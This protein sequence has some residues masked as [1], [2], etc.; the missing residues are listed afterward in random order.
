M[1]EEQRLGEQL[2]A[3]RKARRVTGAELAEAIGVTQ[4][5]VSKMETGRLSPDID[6]LS[7]FA[8]I[9]RLEPT[10]AAELMRLA[11]VVP[12]R[13]HAGELSSFCAL[14]FPDAELGRATPGSGPRGRAPKLAH[15][16]LPAPP[17]SRT[18][19]NRGLRTA[20][21]HPGRSER[22]AHGGAR[23]AFPGFAGKCCWPTGTRRSRS[24][25]PKPPCDVAWRPR[26]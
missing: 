17:G 4:G 22:P 25:S 14:R 12:R 16:R 9:L 8:H 23:R 19:A 5:T 20:C 2:R 15:P 18:P 1:G 3:I 7:K 21:L 13:C 11:G 6:Y 26:T 24:S 10:Q